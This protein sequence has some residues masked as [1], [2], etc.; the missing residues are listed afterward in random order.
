MFMNFQYH[1]SVLTS[2][3]PLKQC[4]FVNVSLLGNSL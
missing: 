3:D 2:V 4:A 1:E